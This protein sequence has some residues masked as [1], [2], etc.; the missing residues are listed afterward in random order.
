[1]RYIIF[2]IDGTLTDTTEVDDH[3]FTKALEDTFNFRGFETDYGHYE[4]TTDSGIIH[5]LFMERDQRTYTEE[6]REH[7]IHNFCA[8]L[9][10]AYADRNDCMKEIPKAGKILNA[11]CA[12]EGISVGLATGGWRESAMFKLSCAG[13][14]TAGCAAASFAQDARARRD[15]IG[16]T[17]LQMNKLH[18]IDMP[19]SEII[20]VGDGKWDYQATQQ[21][22]IQFIGIENKKLEHLADIVKIADYDE[23][24]LH[25]A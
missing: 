20:Y 18:Q 12:K 21:L 17:I 10:E 7:F 16:N 5:Q 25:L 8:L 19:L 13:I 15:I 4:D 1:M 3:C 6:E 24:H 23:L 22:G 14:T 9:K 11:L 2:D